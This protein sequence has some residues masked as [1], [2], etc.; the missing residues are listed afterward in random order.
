MF[1]HDSSHY[2][3]NIEKDNIGAVELVEF[4]ATFEQGATCDCGGGARRGIATKS[5]P[6]QQR[7]SNTCITN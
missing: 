2:S 6:H 4:V 3:S 1:C 5:L 7:E